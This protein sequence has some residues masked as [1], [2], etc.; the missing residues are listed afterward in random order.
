MSPSVNEIIKEIEKELDEEKGI[1]DLLNQMIVKRVTKTA[2]NIQD[3]FGNKNSALRNLVKKDSGNFMK[4]LAEL[5]KKKEHLTGG[6]STKRTPKKS[7]KN[8]SK[9]KSKSKSKSKRKSKRKQQTKKNLK[10]KIVKNL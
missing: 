4:I 9:R 3:I 1:I 2:K 5:Q 10:K 6:C 8:K 7:N